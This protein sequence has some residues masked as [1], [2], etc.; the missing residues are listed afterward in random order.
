[1]KKSASKTMVNAVVCNF[2][3]KYLLSLVVITCK[4]PH[5]TT[6]SSLLLAYLFP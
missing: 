1:M 6:A 4:S 2:D 5:G 3:H